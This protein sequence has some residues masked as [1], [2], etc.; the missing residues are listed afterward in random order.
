MEKTMQAAEESGKVPKETVQKGLVL[1]VDD[2][3]LNREMLS[4]V[5]AD[6][7]YGIEEA[8][9]GV[10][11]LRKIL[12]LK[13]ELAAVLLDIHMPGLNGIEVMERIAARS[14]PSE[15]PVFLITAETDQEIIEKAYILG[16]MD[17]IGKP[18]S[19]S[20]VQRRI[21]TVVDLYRTRKKLQKTVE[22]QEEEIRRQTERIREL[23]LGMIEGLATAVEFRDGASGAHVRR[24]RA[25]TK[26]LLQ[27]SELGR[28]YSDAKIEEIAI[29]SVMHDIGKIAI[30]DAILMK[31]GKLTPEEYE[32]MKTHTTEG[33]RLLESIPSIREMPLFEYAYKIALCH[34]ERWDG[35]GYPLG[36]KGDE[37]PYCAQVVALADVYDA[38][39]TERE[40]KP[41]Y[42]P[43]K[44]MSMI[45]GGECGQFNPKLLEALRLCEPQL[46]QLH[47]KTA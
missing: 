9:D 16:A 37:I 12:A 2:S 31:P 44:A 41:A 1:I 6:A 4:L 33:A 42:S 29:A 23:S 24:I 15:I 43:E 13:S 20:I 45:L 19:S 34:H 30:P 36:L 26:Y 5:L 27:H 22:Y 21:E 32:V 46:R 18:F 38:L 7:G 11:G 10:E 35:K 3:D 14:I 17:V 47:R 25:L 40:Y 28:D 8:E 39:V